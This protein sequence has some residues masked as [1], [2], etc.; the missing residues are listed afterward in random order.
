M[1]PLSSLNIDNIG[2]FLLALSIMMFIFIIVSIWRNCKAGNVIYAI[3]LSI[4]FFLSAATAF[5]V[6]KSIEYSKNN[7]IKES[8]VVG[9]LISV[10][11]ATYIKNINTTT[12][13]IEISKNCEITSSLNGSPLTVNIKQ[14]GDHYL[15]YDSLGKT[16]ECKLITY[17]KKKV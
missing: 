11:E 6:Y 12:Y 8:V 2:Y 1:R 14:H 17:K 9:D 3:L 4:P 16:T 5:I 10:K 13:D 15:S 7:P